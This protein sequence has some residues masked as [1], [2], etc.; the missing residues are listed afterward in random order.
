MIELGRSLSFAP[1]PHQ[2]VLGISVTRQNALE[3]HDPTRMPLSRAI[4][5]A[6]A[7]ASDFFQNLIIPQK[8][9]RV[10]TIDIA[11]HVIERRFDR[12]RLAVTVDTRGKK[13]LQAKAAPHA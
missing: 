3:R 10:M 1:E 11:K 5:Y 13:A 7:T 9:I 6:H 2:R 4:N 12:P 8:P